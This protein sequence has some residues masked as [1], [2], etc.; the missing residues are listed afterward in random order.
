VNTDQKLQALT[1]IG[2][3]QQIVVTHLTVRQSI[4]FLLLKL[5]ILEVAS[6]I[7]TIILYSFFSS[8]DISKQLN[9]NITIFNIPIYVLLVV[10]K[11]CLSLFVIIRWLEEYYEITPV[12]IIHKNGLIF[13]K[14]EGH[15]LDHLGS[16]QMEQSIFGKIFNYGTLKLYNWMSEKEVVLYLI[17]NPFKYHKVLET[18]LPKVDPTKKVIREH[19]VEEEKE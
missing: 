7:G 3:E 10:V 5:F 6:T 9:T 13:K 17:H 11:S 18:L 1:Q 2:N 14:E 19:I 16:L 8:Q 4:F 15:S 12:A